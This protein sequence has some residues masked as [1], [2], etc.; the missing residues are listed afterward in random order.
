MVSSEEF[1]ALSQEEQR[2]LVDERRVILDQNPVREI[3][4]YGA[5]IR[6]LDKPFTTA[7]FDRLQNSRYTVSE[8]AGEIGV[9]E[10]YVRNAINKHRHRRFEKLLDEYSAVLR[11]KDID[12]PALVYSLESIPY[13]ARV[14]D[15]TL[16]CSLLRWNDLLVDRLDVTEWI[17]ANKVTEID[18]DYAWVIANYWDLDPDDTFDFIT[19]FE[20][21]YVETALGPLPL[22]SDTEKYESVR[23]RLAE[24]ENAYARRKGID[25]TTP[26]EKVDAFAGEH[27]KEVGGMGFY[28][29][30]SLILFDLLEYARYEDP[31][32]QD[33]IEDQLDVVLE[34][35]EPKPSN[36]NEASTQ[37]DAESV[38]QDS[39]ESSELRPT[40]NTYEEEF[41]WD[42]R[43]LIIELVALTQEL[44]RLPNET[45]INDRTRFSH[46]AYVKKF[47]SLMAAFRSAG[48]LTE[49]ASNN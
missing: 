17:P 31:S 19:E 47:G 29:S 36:Q 45:E 21:R 14:M 16:S 15:P 6:V 1:Y 38:S 4:E 37:T 7:I 25:D 22:V 2:K 33:V 30:L 46:R 35:V 44:G 27:T 42:K 23:R 18:E 10:K 8:L 28:Q 3:P 49:D 40:S 39:L 32:I 41:D 34:W 9:R 12:G 24:A 11:A 5:P 43:E 48:I 26:R 13:F 20:R